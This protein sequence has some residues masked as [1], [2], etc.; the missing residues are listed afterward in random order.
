MGVGSAEK[1]ACR[2]AS[3]LPTLAN[4]EDSTHG[5]FWGCNPSGGVGIQPLEYTFLQWPLGEVP[6]PTSGPLNPI[7]RIRGALDLGMGKG[8]GGDGVQERNGSKRLEWESGR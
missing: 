3:A 2:P 5:R 4:L 7:T 6:P 1:L 8:G